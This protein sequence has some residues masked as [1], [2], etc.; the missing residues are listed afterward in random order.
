[1]YE[2]S[3]AIVLRI[4]KLDDEKR[5][6]EVYTETRGILS[7]KFTQTKGKRTKIKSTYFLPLTI[8]EL[9]Y[10]YRE[11]FSV[12]TI[13]DLSLQFSMQ[14]SCFNPYKS[15]MV[16]FLSE[17]LAYILRKEPQNGSLFQYLVS[18]F[19]WLD[20][21]HSDFM[22]FHLVFMVQLT[23][24]LGI[25]PFWDSFQ[26]GFYFDMQDSEFTDCPPVPGFFLSPEQTVLLAA[27]YR[28]DFDSMK[29]LVLSREDRNEFL[30]NMICYYQI[31]FPGFPEMKSLSV[32]SEL[33]V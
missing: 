21:S 33:F 5:I 2:K 3:R 1:M 28:T 29:F 24:F 25:P 23:R 11:R 14:M 12:Q 32:L 9:E 26:Q 27:L 16:L 6:A 30:K 20:A 18:S 15:A 22:S 10:D 7:F 8:L 13:G 4:H 19:H 17:F 31:H